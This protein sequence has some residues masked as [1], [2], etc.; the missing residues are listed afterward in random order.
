MPMKAKLE[1]QLL[2]ELSRRNIDLITEWIIDKPEGISILIEFFLKHDNKVAM[3]AVWV[4]EKLSERLT[5][6]AAKLVE[7]LAFQE[8]AVF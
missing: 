1:Q 2:A 6:I 4:L 7:T 5:H 8:L 3:R